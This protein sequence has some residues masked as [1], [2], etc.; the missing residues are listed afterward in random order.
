MVRRR[1]AV[2]FSG[3]GAG[4]D[5]WKVNCGSPG[6]NCGSPREAAAAVGPGPFLGHLWVLARSE[7]FL[8]HLWVPEKPQE[9]CEADCGSPPF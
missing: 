9:I 4:V 6:G 2:S 3:R 8:G 1:C 7:D 5:G